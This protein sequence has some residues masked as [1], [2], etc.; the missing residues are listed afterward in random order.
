MRTCLAKDL[1]RIQL[2]YIFAEDKYHQQH[3][4]RK[5][6]TA[7]S[8]ARLPCALGCPPPTQGVCIRPASTL[9]V[10]RAQHGVTFLCAVWLIDNAS[11]LPKNDNRIS[12]AQSKRMLCEQATCPHTHGHWQLNWRRITAHPSVSDKIVITFEW[13]LFQFEQRVWAHHPNPAHRLQVYTSCTHQLKN[14]DFSSSRKCIFC[15]R[16]SYA[17]RS[18]QNISAFTEQ[19]YVD[20]HTNTHLLVAMA[21]IQKCVAW[22]VCS[23]CMR[24]C[25]LVQREPSRRRLSI[26]WLSCP[27]LKHRWKIHFWE[28]SNSEEHRTASNHM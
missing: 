16:R 22:I 3:A 25:G 1:C 23:N 10:R 11:A 20:A 18:Q 2:F 19:T 12:R 13:Y 27:S 24:T 21:I 6:S 17:F 28:Y 5:L 8:W 7:N 15:F 4:N 14:Y 26:G 9:G